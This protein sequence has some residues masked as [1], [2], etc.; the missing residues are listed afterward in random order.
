MLP[1]VFL[2][3]G[4]VDTHGQPHNAILDVGRYPRAPRASD[5]LAAAFEAAGF[6][7]VPRSTT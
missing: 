2:E 1:A 3:P 7:S 6:A 5:A 4:V